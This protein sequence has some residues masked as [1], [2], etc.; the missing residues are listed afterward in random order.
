MGPSCGIKGIVCTSTDRTSPRL[1]EDV[2]NISLFANVAANLAT[3]LRVAVDGCKVAG[4][5]P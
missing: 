2:E 3:V 5:G 1:T 4:S